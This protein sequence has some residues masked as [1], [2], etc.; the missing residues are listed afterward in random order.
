MVHAAYFS[1]TGTT[2]KIIDTLTSQFDGEATIHDITLTAPSSEV[3]LESNDVFILGAPVYAG[4]IPAI[5]AERLK[6][7]TGNNTLAVI[8]AVYGNREYDNALVEMQDILESQGF[9]VIAAGAF[10]AQ[11][12]IFPMVASGRPDEKD[13]AQVA[14]FGKDIVAILDGVTDIM[15]LQRLE[16]K[17]NRPYK[18]ANK[19]ALKPSSDDACTQCGVCATE[20][21]V[22]AIDEAT[23]ASDEE[24]CIA[25]AR[26]IAICPTGAR[27]FR[28]E[29][30]AMAGAK[31]SAAFST[32]KYP[33]TYLAK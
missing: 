3:S 19:P 7:F 31:F 32:P 26:C 24:K 4:R 17:G 30:Y 5:Q 18:E 14:Q 20:C 2:K 27:N 13:L 25:C 6:A 9:K 10:I 8:V 33:E 21:P 11:H 28:E 1:A 23:L 16:L 12:S 22:G 29:M 15:S